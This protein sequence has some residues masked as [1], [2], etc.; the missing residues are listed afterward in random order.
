MSEKLEI[1]KLGSTNFTVFKTKFKSYL[2]IKGLSKAL[3][4]NAEPPLAEEQAEIA[5]AY[6]V[7]ACPDSLAT[8]MNNLPNALAVWNELHRIYEP[9]TKAR[10]LNLQSEL[11][12]ATI[13]PGEAVSDFLLRVSQKFTELKE[14]SP[15]VEEATE[16]LLQ[17]AKLPPRFQSVVEHFVN[18]EDTLTFTA[19]QGRIRQH[20]Q[21]HQ[22]QSENQAA[23]SSVP[24]FSALRTGSNSGSGHVT[25][26]RSSGSSGQRGGGRSRPT[27]Q[28]RPTHIPPGSCWNCGQRGHHSSVCES[29]PPSTWSYPSLCPK[30]HR[31]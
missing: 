8:V 23:V 15:S 31:Y 29:P 13:A 17:L 20:E 1:P 7:M 26:G 4:P 22:L 21:F 30:L 16:V 11:K 14:A 24:A 12:L 28:T 10:V 6:L 3:V 25:H 5:K 19:V 2:V 27:R 18:V 9:E